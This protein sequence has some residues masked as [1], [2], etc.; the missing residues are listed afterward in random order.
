MHRRRCA[1]FCKNASSYSGLL[2]EEHRHCFAAWDWSKKHLKVRSKLWRR[3]PWLS[4]H[5]EPTQ[6][7]PSAQSW[8]QHKRKYL[9]VLFFGTRL[10]SRTKVHIQYLQ[11]HSKHG[12]VLQRWHERANEEWKFR[13]RRCWRFCWENSWRD[14]LQDYRGLLNFVKLYSSQW[15]KWWWDISLSTKWAAKERV[16]S[17]LN[18]KTAVHRQ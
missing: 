17:G 6:L 15:Q 12:K 5:H 3:K 18:P 9:L 4:L 7:Q 2:R 10:Q 11:L 16:I 14:L 1:I 13:P 8:F